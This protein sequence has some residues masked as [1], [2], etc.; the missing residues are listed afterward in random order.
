MNRQPKYRFYAT[1]LDS[2]EGYLHSDLLWEEYWGKSENPGKTAEEFEAEQFQGL[3]DRINRVPFDSEAADRG[4]AFNEIV[5][6]MIVGRKSEKMQI[7]RVYKHSNV[8]PYE[9]CDRFCR[10][11][12][13]DFSRQC[14]KYLDAYNRAIDSLPKEVEALKATYNNRA[15][16]FPI[17]LCREFAEYFK[18]AVPQVLT[19][20][21]LPTRYGEV[22]LYGYID[23][24][25]PLSVHDIKTTG[26][27]SVGKFRHN[28][29]HRVY[30][31]CL[32]ENGNPI[33]DFEYNVAALT[34]G[35]AD[36][37]LLKAETFTEAY[38]FDPDRDVP[39]LTEHCERLV[40]FL[41]ANRHLITDTRIFGE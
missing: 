14:G 15:F 13:C 27:Y 17:A 7:E 23:E 29:Q 34:F 25:M 39:I 33:Y 36:G 26:K 24:L 8:D 22:Q 9:V 18:G 19:K 2:F 41:E 10:E 21:L 30:P 31:Y 3:I 12:N 28:W 40:E 5:D 38:R 6:C 1:L 32:I 4:T 16:E 20:A 11:R 35:R 37:R